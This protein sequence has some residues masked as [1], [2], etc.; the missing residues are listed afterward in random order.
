MN[1][2]LV[3][4]RGGLCIISKNRSQRVSQKDGLP[5]N[6]IVG[7]LA[8]KYDNIWCSTSDGIGLLYKNSSRFRVFSESDGIQ[9]NYNFYGSYK[10]PSGELLFGS[11]K[12]ITIIH[13]DS[14]LQKNKTFS[15]Q[16]SV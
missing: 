13:P 2:N 10:M 4:H 8:D 16:K 14:V 9:N 7:V 12:A 3:R 1:I 6:N 11:Q 5:S 15:D